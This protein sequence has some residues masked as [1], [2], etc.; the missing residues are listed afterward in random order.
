[1]SES[2]SVKGREGYSRVMTWIVVDIEADGAAPGLYS[3]VCFGAVVLSEALDQTFYGRVRPIS[4]A[5]NAD[6]LAVSGFSREEHEAFPE[7][8]E[9]MTAFDAW[10]ADHSKG[11]PIFVS[12]NNSFDF[13]FINYYF[14]L[15]LGR[16]PFGWSSRRIGDLY[17]GLVKDP[18]APWKQLRRTAHTHHP[19]D[20]AM[21]NAQA[22]LAMRE[23]GLK[24]KL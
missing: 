4:Q 19:V 6:A 14:H 15:T 23:M 13:A 22:L 3:M 18:R 21:G 11:R 20:D 10:L 7:P 8:L 17:A 5:W 12:D 9:T 24:I 2:L 1:M 16:N